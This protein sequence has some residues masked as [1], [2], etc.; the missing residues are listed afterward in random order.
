MGGILLIGNAQGFLDRHRIQ[1]EQSAVLACAC[2]NVPLSRGGKQPVGKLLVEGLA[3]SAASNA[4]RLSR[5][6][7]LVTSTTHFF[8]AVLPASP[9]AK[10]RRALQSKF[11]SPP[12]RRLLKLLFWPESS[13]SKTPLGLLALRG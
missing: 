7:D 11:K 8:G 1:P 4:V 10:K 9:I 12:T 13:G 5:G 3:G 2:P 6:S